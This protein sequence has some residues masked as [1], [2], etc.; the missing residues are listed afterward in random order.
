MFQQ[1]FGSCSTIKRGDGWHTYFMYNLTDGFNDAPWLH[2]PTRNARQQRRKS[3]VVTWR[4]NVSII[5]GSIQIFQEAGAGPTGAQHNHL[6]LLLLGIF[7]KRRLGPC[8]RKRKQAS[9]ATDTAQKGSSHIWKRQKSGVLQFATERLK[10]RD[11]TWPN[12]LSIICPN[13]TNGRHEAE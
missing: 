8:L 1:S 7:E 11:G 12:K 3:K 4:E 13:E 5:L 2:R 10:I 6:L 9:S